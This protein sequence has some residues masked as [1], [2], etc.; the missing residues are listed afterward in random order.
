MRVCP[1]LRSWPTLVLTRESAQNSVRRRGR[2]RVR[3]EDGKEATLE[4]LRARLRD[5]SRR[6]LRTGLTVAGVAL[7]IFTLVVLGALGEH[8][9]GLGD[10]ARDYTAGL[11][12]L[13]TK[14]DRKG[15]NPGIGEDLLA[16]IRADESVERVEP[17]I[18]LWF[19]GFDLE[20]DPL[21]FFQPKP[22][23]LGLPAA[24]AETM[25]P[26][27]KLIEGRW[28]RAG[29]E[30][31]AMV[32]SWLAR[33]RGL[34]VGGTVTI[35][36]KAYELVGIYTAP[37]I[38]IVPA[39]IAP[40]EVLERDYIRPRVERAERFLGRAVEQRP[41]LAALLP[42]ELRPKRLA[43]TLVTR[44]QRLYRMYDVL[45]KDR[46]PDGTRRLAARLRREV[47]ELAIVDPDS[48]AK[49][50]ETAILAFL[51]ITGLV[52][53]V[54]TVVGGLLIVNTMAMAVLERRREIAIKVAIG[55]TPAQVVSEFLLEAA[56][57]G[58]FGALL[59]LLA[60]LAA[61]LIAEP[62]LVARLGT[63]EHLFRITPR[64]LGLATLY[65]VG[66][67]MAAGTLPALRAA[68]VDPA[69][70]LREL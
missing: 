25:R 40:F 65:G 55:A 15:E 49:N 41:E 37:D 68:R 28:I 64:L 29:D 66:M 12:R 1:V 27:V 23:V 11:L 34:H 26:G 38:P 8:F 67:G 56:L 60:G 9:R 62:W 44:Q 21:G 51:I 70:R 54:S 20:G 42:A 36:N 30:R 19:D 6:R 7:G 39:G 61:I 50:I 35:R 48:V 2:R 47:P 43:A 31:R 3:A 17:L 53:A 33:R 45:P 46:S 13:F 22:L 24:A 4:T 63:G 5:L 59:G 52:T 57:I 58:L 69:L 32:I 16:R 18:V 10:E 14:T